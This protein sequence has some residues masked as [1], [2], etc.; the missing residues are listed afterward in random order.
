MKDDKNWFG[1]KFPAEAGVGFMHSL[2][3]PLFRAP[4]KSPRRRPKSPAASWIP[5]R[6]PA[7]PPASIAATIFRPSFSVSTPPPNRVRGP[8]RSLRPPSTP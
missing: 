8:V 3:A 5:A 4:V 6:T 2:F 1:A 7:G